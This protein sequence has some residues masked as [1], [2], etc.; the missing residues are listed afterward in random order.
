M[1]PKKVFD[2]IEGDCYPFAPVM[3][4]RTLEERRIAAR[5]TATSLML[6]A[7]LVDVKGHPG[8]KIRVTDTSTNGMAFEARREFKVDERLVI[9]IP[10]VNGGGKVVLSQ[11]KHCG[12]GG[13][14]LYRVGVEFLDAVSLPRGKCGLPEKWGK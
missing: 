8:L 1:R 7:V 9:K 10:I 4:A 3:I 11:V 5:R 2:Q 14:N 13:L 6:E 12:A